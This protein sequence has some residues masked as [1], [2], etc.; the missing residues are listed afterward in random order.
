MRSAST[1]KSLGD[2]III[3]IIIIMG[4]CKASTVRLKAL[5][6]YSITHIMYVEME[7]VISNERERKKEK[8]RKKKKKLT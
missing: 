2:I 6:K 3:I 8:E 7:N 4:I 5:S 1:R